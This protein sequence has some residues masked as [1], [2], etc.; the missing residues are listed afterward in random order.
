MWVCV[1]RA[2]LT[3]SLKNNWLM[4]KYPSLRVTFD[5]VLGRV[6]NSEVW[7]LKS[8]MYCMRLCVLSVGGAPPKE[9]SLHSQMAP[10][11][12]GSVV[13]P[14]ACFAALSLRTCVT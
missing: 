11:D 13:Q 4:A 1:A 6:E 8:V 9:I 14:T 12:E 7:K 5:L 10:A 3:A 2:M